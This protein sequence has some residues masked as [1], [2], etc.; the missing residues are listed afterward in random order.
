M[1]KKV[2][3]IAF[4]LPQFY[5]IPENDLWWGKGFTEWL[6]VAKARPLY[7]G[8]YQP[9]L[10]ADLGFY[11]LRLPEVREAQAQMAREAGIEGFCYWHYW[12]G[13]G[14]ELLERPFNEV[15]ESGNPDYP[16]CLAWANR[17]WENKKWDK[18]GNNKVLIEQ[19]YPSEEDDIRH[20]YRLLPAFKDERYIK[21]DGKP[22]FLV[23]YTRDEHAISRFIRVWRKLAVENGLSGFFFVAEDADSRRK[24]KNLSLGFDAIYNNDAFNIHHHLPLIAK[25]C[26]WVGREW[27]KIPSIFSYKRAIKYMLNEDAKSENTFPVVFPNWDHSPRSGRSAKIL[28]HSTPKLYKYLINNTIKAISGK[29]EEKRIVFIKSWNE[30]GEGNYLE[31]DLKYG[32][33]YLNVMREAVNEDSKTETEE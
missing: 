32:K 25:V 24:S 20:F 12:F 33:A 18:R 21:V 1:D 6:N 10:P 4:Y 28:G 14:K 22:L 3:F 17:S 8:H 23:Q 26:L 19:T 29:P 16:F 7:P 2:R 9:K 31:P 27:L 30:W 11:D 5:P 15:L 13:N